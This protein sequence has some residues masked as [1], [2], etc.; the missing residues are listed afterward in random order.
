MRW[1]EYR[2][3]TG[4]GLIARERAR[5]QEVEGYTDEHDDEHVIGRTPLV[6][7]YLHDPFGPVRMSFECIRPDK[8][9]E[10]RLVQAGALIAAELD[11]RMR[12]KGKVPA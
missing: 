2:T 9:D 12:A 3:D 10:T 5:Q 1:D 11:R 4:V 7:V 8:D 6:H